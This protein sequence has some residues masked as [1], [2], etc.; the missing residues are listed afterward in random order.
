[1][2]LSLLHLSCYNGDIDKVKEYLTEDNLNEIIIVYEE[3]ELN[4]SS[5]IFIESK[6]LTPIICAIENNHLSIIKYLHQQGANLYLLELVFISY[7][8]FLI[9]FL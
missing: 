6:K 8:N 2:E 4:D 1:M 5:W 9:Y 7:S 3:K